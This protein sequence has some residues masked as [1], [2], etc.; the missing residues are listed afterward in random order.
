M[1][2]AVSHPV[3]TLL[4]TGLCP[5]VPYHRNHLAR[6]EKSQTPFPPRPPHPRQLFL[7]AR[8]PHATRNTQHATRTTPHASPPL[9]RRS[10]GLQN[11]PLGR[12]RPAPAQRPKL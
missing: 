4:R 3:S 5:T 10:H 2:V 1:R 12:T 7:R 11:R 8:P 9:S 6:H